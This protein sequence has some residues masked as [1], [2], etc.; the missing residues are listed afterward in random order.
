MKNPLRVY[1]LSAERTVCEQKVLKKPAHPV[2]TKGPLRV[3][4]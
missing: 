3:G 2:K 4:E 1:V